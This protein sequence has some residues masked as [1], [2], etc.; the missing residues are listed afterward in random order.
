MEVA[1]IAPYSLV[2]VS[3]VLSF[4]SLDNSQHSLSELSVVIRCTLNSSD[5]NNPFVIPD[6][7]VAS[8]DAIAN[9]KCL[10]QFHLCSLKSFF[11]TKYKIAIRRPSVK[12]SSNIKAVAMTVATANNVFNRFSIFMTLFSFC[13]LRK[14]AS[15]RKVSYNAE[16]ALSSLLVSVSLLD[17]HYKRFD[18]IFLEF[19]RECFIDQ[20]LWKFNPVTVRIKQS[21]P[22]NSIL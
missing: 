16:R 20:L 7:E 22:V 2:S 14:S 11:A 21:L 12:L 10:S 9:L 18:F 8:G 1:T 4:E 5:N 15:S 17:L 13:L 19:V 3:S 6:N